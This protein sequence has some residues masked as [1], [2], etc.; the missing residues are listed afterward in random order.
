MKTFENLRIGTKISFVVGMLA[1]VAATIGW[2]GIDAMRT[3]DARVDEITRAS[4]R[5]VL[6][7]RVNGLILSVVMDS[8][9]IYMSRDRA[10]A[11]RYGKPLLAYLQQMQK[12][13]GEWK[14]LLPPEQQDGFARAETNARQF[15][16]F[17]TELVRRGYEAGSPAAR[18]YGDND[19][20]RRNRQALNVEI[21]KLAE[22]N[23]ALIGELDAGLSIYYQAR[24]VTMIVVAVVGIALAIGLAV[25]VVRR[26]VTRPIVGMTGLMGRLAGGDL[27]IAVTGLGRQDE[28]GAMAKAVQVFKDNAQTARR[29]EGEQK[30]EQVRKE[31][32]QQA[33]EGFIK[34]FDDSVTG[35]LRTLASSST[36]LQN[37]ARSMTTTAEGASRQATAVATA[38][39]EAST[40]VQTVAAAAEELSSS[41]QEISRQVTEST[42][43]AG[44]ALDEATRTNE[45]VQALA[46]A[47]QKIGDVVK[48]IADIAG[49]TNLL[50]LNATIEAARAGESGKGFAVVASEVKSLAT[51]T[52]RA[53]EEIA[54]QIKAIQ[55]ATGDSVQAISGI[56]TT[57]GRIN[58]IATTIASA[59]E[60]QG[61]ATQEIAR[62]VQQASAGTAE[63]SSNIAGVTQAATE[64]GAAATQVLGASS[65]LARQGETLRSEVNQF[66]VSIRAA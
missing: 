25:V 38:S 8:R 58:E 12:L 15:A 3:Y 23:N 36:E 65:E 56:G 16:E 9:G 53:T 26:F 20:N 2:M 40:N 31:Q 39:E 47:A 55:G 33:V 63:V 1:L 21:Q 45:K 46:E 10:E 34:R 43:I 29:L 18:E 50:A 41:I 35:S 49:Q 14:M 4:Q 44:Q 42:R 61:A 51:Q 66:L 30:A 5:A 48:L 22:L 52:A 32:R 7:E 37:T 11:E 60:E 59:V 17:R 19:A 54:A 27:E 28:I 64:T 57:I 6:G 13:L 24:L 62:N